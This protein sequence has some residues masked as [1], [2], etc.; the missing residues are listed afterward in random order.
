MRRMFVVRP[1]VCDGRSAAGAGGEPVAQ[2]QRFAA[3]AREFVREFQHR[4]VLLGHVPLQVGDFLF[5][6]FNAFAQR[7]GWRL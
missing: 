6:T 5:E 2:R 1:V 4:L 3:Q 7:S